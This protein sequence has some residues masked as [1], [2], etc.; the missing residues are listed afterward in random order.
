MVETLKGLVQNMTYSSL[1]N[2]HGEVAV[3]ET[4]NSSNKAKCDL[5]FSDYSVT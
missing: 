4:D 2:K 1:A 5:R 3:T